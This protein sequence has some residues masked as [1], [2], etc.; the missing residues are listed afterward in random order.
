MEELRSMGKRYNVKVTVETFLF[1]PALLSAGSCSYE[2]AAKK[3][4][5]LSE[6]LALNI[7]VI[8]FECIEQ[9]QSSVG[10]CSPPPS[11]PPTDPPTEDNM[12]SYCRQTPCINKTT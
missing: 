12:C 2:P 5:G 7:T 6:G 8:V 3:K 9:P 4:K 1:V 10:D 11:P